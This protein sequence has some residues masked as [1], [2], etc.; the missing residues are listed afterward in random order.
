MESRRVDSIMVNF[1][2]KHLNFEKNPE[3]GRLDSPKKTTV[4]SP[5]QMNGWKM[6]FLLK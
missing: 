1:W 4:I 6:Y 2:S 3:I 5:L